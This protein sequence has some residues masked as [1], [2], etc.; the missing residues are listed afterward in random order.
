MTR[1]LN[2]SLCI[3]STMVQFLCPLNQTLVNEI[4][5]GGSL[6]S[7]VKTNLRLWIIEK[8]EDSSYPCF[9]KT[10]NNE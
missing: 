10:T 1:D 9:L 7:T 6:N 8:K 4:Q 2:S 3:D 5:T